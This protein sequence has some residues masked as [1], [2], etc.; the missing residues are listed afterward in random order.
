MGKKIAVI[1]ILTIMA[2]LVYQLP[3]KEIEGI[4]ALAMVV[5]TA[6]A[7][8]SEGEAQYFAVLNQRFC[9]LEELEEILREAAA[10]VGLEIKKVEKSEGETF[11]VVDTSGKTTSGLKTHLV[12]QSNPGDGKK[13]QP[14]TYLLLF[15]SEASQ[16]DLAAEIARI[17]EV[18]PNYAPNGQLTYYLTGYLA[19]QADLQE[20]EKIARRGLSAVRGKVVEGMQS[21]G[22]VS[23]TAY[24]P[25]LTH[26]LTTQGE[27]INLN[28]VIRYD[29]YLQK[30]VVSAGFPLI[31]SPY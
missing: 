7:Q 18:M 10:L 21:D 1:L 13:I 31:H 20:M 3:P 19:G 8:I 4:E 29:D 25:L 14:Q 28:I 11:R 30:T 15:C 26:H 16:K 12:V 27:K 24:T 9:K 23:L 5:E 22:L 17:N 2:C 6:G